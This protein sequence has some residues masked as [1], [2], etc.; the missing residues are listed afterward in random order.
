MGGHHRLY[1]LFPER[2]LPLKARLIRRHIYVVSAQT[3]TKSYEWLS[4]GN[5]I[6][7]DHMIAE[8]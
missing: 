6:I 4:E 7:I 8:A 2:S 3:Y 1:H 5:Y